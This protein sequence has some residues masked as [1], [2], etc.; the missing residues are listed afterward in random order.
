M[1]QCEVI[2]MYIL[3]KR[4]QCGYTQQQVADYLKV[5]CQAVSKWEKRW[6]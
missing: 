6:D 4:K 5:S 2:G 1:E 3:D